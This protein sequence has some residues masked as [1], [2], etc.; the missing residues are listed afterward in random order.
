M[1][2]PLRETHN[3]L[4]EN[5]HAR[6]RIWVISRLK[7]QLGHAW[8]QEMELKMS[9]F[10]HYD[11]ASKIKILSLVFNSPYQIQAVTMVYITKSPSF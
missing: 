10:F 4:P 11:G 8:K 2:Q 1:K 9:N 5:L 7:T 3:T 6:F